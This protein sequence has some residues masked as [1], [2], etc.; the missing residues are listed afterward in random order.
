[1]SYHQELSSNPANT[2]ILWQRCHNVGAS[3]V[4][5]SVTKLWQ[6]SNVDTV[7]HPS[8]IMWTSKQCCVNVVPTLYFNQNPN[9]STMLSQHWPNLANIQTMFRQRCA[10][11]VAMPLSKLGT[12]IGDDVETTFSQCCVNDVSM[13][14]PNIGEQSWDKVQAASHESCGNVALN[15]GD[16]HWDNTQATLWEHCVNNRAPHQ[17]QRSGNTVW[18]L[19]QHRRPTLYLDRLSPDY[20]F[21]TSACIPTLAQSHL[22]TFMNNPTNHDSWVNGWM[23][24]QEIS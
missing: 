1:M 24:F 7:K 9:I 10:N 19:S 6:H 17:G 8:N 3:V 16:W 4:S 2:P 13:S 21:A 12:D 23:N 18:T 14:V 20:T 5:T 15:V 11:V 22:Q